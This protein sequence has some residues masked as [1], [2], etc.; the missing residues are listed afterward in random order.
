MCLLGWHP[1]PFLF[2]PSS[3]HTPTACSFPPL[4]PP[5]PSH[6]RPSS[7]TIES[8]KDSSCKCTSLV[9][10]QVLY[11]SL[12][13][14]P[15][16]STR[17]Q[18]LSWGSEEV[19]SFYLNNTSR[20]VY[21]HRR[22]LPKGQRPFGLSDAS[23]F[24]I[25]T[26]AGLTGSVAMTWAL[27]FAEETRSLISMVGKAASPH[28][29]LFLMFSVFVLALSTVL[30]LEHAA[31]AEKKGQVYLIETLES[32]EAAGEESRNLFEEEGLVDTVF[33]ML[34]G[35]EDEGAEAVPPFFKKVVPRQMTKI[36]EWTWD[37]IKGRYPGLWRLAWTRLPPPLLPLSLERRTRTAVNLCCPAVRLPPRLALTELWWWWLLPSPRRWARWPRFGRGG[38]VSSA[39]ARGRLLGGSPSLL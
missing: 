1:S 8:E 35:A 22:F 19:N 26:G 14:F 7:F 6:P 9:L 25:T 34:L 29:P 33:A 30:N 5:H 24:L 3:S 31:P 23:P 10:K 2:P 13:S 20:K 16:P 32:G 36:E 18:L 39:S 17:K 27:T 28:W 11:H 38:S 12:L 21:H 37:R 15:H 4:S